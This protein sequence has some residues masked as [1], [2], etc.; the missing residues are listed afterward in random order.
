MTASYQAAATLTV[1]RG[2]N[3]GRQFD[4]GATAVTIGRQA[5]CDIQVEDTWMSRQHARIVWTG[6]AY[7][8]EDLGSTNGTFVNGE[9]V[10]G[11]RALRTGDRLQ[12]GDQVELAFQ[13]RAPA[14][15]AEKPAFSGTAAPPPK[16]RARL[17]VPALLGLLL[18]LIAGGMIYYFLSDNGQTETETPTVQGALPQPTTA[19]L[20][21]TPTAT[22]TAIPTASPAPTLTP[23]RMSISAQANAIFVG[24]MR[25][26]SRGENASANGGEI[27]FTTSADGT[28]LVSM[29]YSLFSGKCTY[30]SSSSTTTVSGSSKSTLYFNE[31]VPIEEGKFA[32]N[33][34]GVRANGELGSPTEA[35]G[36]ITIDKEETMAAPPYERFVCHYGTWTWTASVE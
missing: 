14:P 32:F 28:A 23:T 20:T 18:V 27:E 26:S 15:L 22:P 36:E 8:I 33:L 29:S 12:L 25:I 6:T 16:S 30:V 10:V 7:E 34:M 19:T 35:E 9:R 2:P 3:A 13:L 11:S 4:I 21:A 24:P 5:Q 31:P 17:W 1:S